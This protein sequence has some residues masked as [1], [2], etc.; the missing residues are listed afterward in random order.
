[1]SVLVLAR[2]LGPGHEPGP[3][4]EPGPG[5]DFEVVA[6]R[7][8]V[9]PAA[10]LMHVPL[11]QLSDFDLEFVPPVPYYTEPSERLS[12]IV[13]LYVVVEPGFEAEAEAALA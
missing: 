8:F 12:Y 13:G 6:R 5:P 1:M 4:L 9:V 11:H 7:I 3:E 10:P 2:E